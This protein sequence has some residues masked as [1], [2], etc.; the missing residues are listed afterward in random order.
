MASVRICR[1]EGALRHAPLGEPGRDED[2]LVA[3]AQPTDVRKPVDGHVV[4]RRP[5][6]LGRLDVEALA[7]ERL[8]PRVP[9]VRPRIGARLVALAA[10]DQHAPAV[11]SRR[12]AHRPRRLVHGDVHAAWRIGGV[13]RDGVRLRRVRPGEEEAA[14]E[15]RQLGCDDDVVGAHEAMLRLDDARLAAPNA[16]RARQLEDTAAVPVDEPRERRDVL[17]RMELRLAVHAGGGRD[18]IR[19]VRLGRR[20]A[21]RHPRAAPPRPRARRPAPSPATRSRRSWPRAR[22]RSRCHARGQSPRPP[23]SPPGSSG[24][25]AAPLPRPIARSAARTRGCARQSASPSCSPSR[26][27]R[28]APTRA[29]RRSCLPAS[30]G[31]LS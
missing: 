20:A 6:V 27:S 23:R 4:V 18:R 31:A 2:A 28:R 8:E 11:R 26:R 25:T 16:G 10:D 14:I 1:R 9:F 29:T 21:P 13:R 7:H 24:R 3:A 5:A 19:Q 30:G 12:R 17:P 22:S 15:E